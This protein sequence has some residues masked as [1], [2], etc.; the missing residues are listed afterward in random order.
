MAM[1]GMT[2]TAYRQGISVPVDGI[3]R[4]LSGMADSTP[5]LHDALKGKNIYP[6]GPVNEAS[7]LLGPLHAPTVDAPRRDHSTPVLTLLSLA[8]QTPANTC[9]AHSHHV[10][11]RRP[12][13]SCGVVK[14]GGEIHLDRGKTLGVKV[15]PE[16]P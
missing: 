10:T 1:D 6:G 2:T 4:G 8:L 11:R 13:G 9:R 3:A 12:I 7:K 14:H 16:I 15:T 5:L